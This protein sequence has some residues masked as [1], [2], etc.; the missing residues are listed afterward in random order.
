MRAI[1]VEEF[2]GP[3]V[4]IEREVEAPVPQ[5]GEWLVQV[6]GAGLNY[7]DTHHAENSYLSPASVPFVP[8]MEVI[9]EV[10]NG[11]ETGRRVCGFVS[12]GGGYAEYAITRPELCFTVPPS[13]GDIAALSLLVQGLTAHHLVHTSARLQPGE[14]IV[15]NA[16]AGGVGSLAVQIAAQAKAG[17]VIA[18]ASSTEKLALAT[19]LGATSTV[20]TDGNESAKEL[21]TRLRE[22]NDGRGIDVVLEMVGGTTFDAGLRALGRFG[23]IICY[24]NASRTPQTPVNPS[25]LMVGSKSVVGYWLVDSMAEPEVNIAPVLAGL[26]ESVATGQLRTLEGSTYALADAAQ[27]HRDIRGRRTTGKIVLDP[28]IG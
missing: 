15:V 26:V 5:D 9:G 7:A 24:G 19:D 27:A 17:N 28:R 10:L 23:R 8:G 4:L 11:P 13:V 6:H 22:V 14:S 12:R 3:E 2:G 21:A 1:Q 16:A 18:C 25:E 20:L